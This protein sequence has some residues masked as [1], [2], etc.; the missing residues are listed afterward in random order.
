MN[1][2]KK[3]VWPCITMIVLCITWGLVNGDKAIENAGKFV[4]WYGSSKALEGV[5]D[6]STEYDIDP[7]VWLTSQEEPV[8]VRISVTDSQLD[9]TISTHKLKESIPLSFVLLKG[10]KRPFRDILDVEAFDYIM[11]KKTTFAT[12]TMRVDGSNRL[13]IDKEHDYGDLFPAHAIL[14][15]KSAIAFPELTEQNLEKNDGGD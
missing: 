2:L 7:P 8:E 9:G 1:L 5:W 15:K 6:N 12:F 13:I 3:T 4:D 11:G 14:V 10:T